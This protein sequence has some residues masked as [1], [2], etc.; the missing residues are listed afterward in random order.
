[1][2]PPSAGVLH[3]KIPFDPLIDH[4]VDIVGPSILIIQVVHI[5]L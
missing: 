3:G 2:F 4:G 1:M 5:A